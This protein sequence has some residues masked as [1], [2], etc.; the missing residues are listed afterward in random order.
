LV[1]ALPILLVYS[2]PFRTSITDQVQQF[3]GGMTRGSAR[4][5]Q[6]ATNLR[7]LLW[8]EAIKRGVESGMFGLGPG[9]HLDIPDE[10]L[11]G[12][13]HTADRK[14]VE[15]PRQ[16]LAPNFEAH[17]TVLDL[18]A[19]GGLIAVLSF[20]LL[21]AT[22]VLTTLRL[23]LDALTTMMLGLA[24]FSIFHLIVRQPNVWFA[25]TYAM[26]TA[27]ARQA[28]S[29]LPS[30]LRDDRHASAQIMARNPHFR[31]RSGLMG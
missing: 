4:H 13:R 28:S 5:T 12:R 18:F 14:H 1:L 19:Q 10:V 20:V 15:H 25:V 11:D 23:K 31:F 30:P 2:V 9:P 17:N 6:E 8:K 3:A 21:M 22:T 27:F 26:V 24:I 29:N 7:L 16:S